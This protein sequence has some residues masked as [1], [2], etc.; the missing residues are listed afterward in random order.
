MNVG[1]LGTGA[2]GKT[3]AAKL[4]SLGHAV[5][6][7]TRDV[8]ATMANTASDVFGN[9]PFSVWQKSHPGVKLAGF[10][11]AAAHGEVIINA[12]NGSA[13]IDVLER[14][15]K[16]L[17]GKIL[18]DLS[19]PLDFSKGMPPSLFVCNTDSLAEQIQKAFPRVKVVKTLNTVNASVMVNPGAVASGDHHLFLSGNDAT[20]KAEVMGLLKSW[21]GWRNF[22]DLGD[23]TTAR[24][25]EM[26]LPIW[27]QLWGAL[28]TPMF[29]FKIVR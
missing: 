4:A 22:I 14:A 6:I 7:G 19:N 25:A 1:I 10:A 2:V 13:S 24:G 5:V 17:D 29:N 3:L 26:I 21:F 18:I 23:I 15:G 28:K 20:A 27:L 9:P 8:A 12:T 16:S 11:D